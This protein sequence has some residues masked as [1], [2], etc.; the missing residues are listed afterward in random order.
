MRFA[1]MTSQPA[2]PLRQSRPDV[3]RA[4]EA[5]WCMPRYSRCW[6]PRRV[7]PA[8]QG[9]SAPLREDS[10]QALTSTAPTPTDVSVAAEAALPSDEEDDE[11]EEVD[12]EEEEVAAAEHKREKAVVLE[13]SS[14]QPPAP[15][16]A[17]TSTA[18]PL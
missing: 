6:P 2:E 18:S 10:G 1:E 5:P 17:G 16:P 3:L 13:R 4:R 8:P 15:A 9:S 12:E 7:H 11:W 14:R